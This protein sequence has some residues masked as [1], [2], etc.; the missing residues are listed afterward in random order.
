MLA[1]RQVHAYGVR[2][3]HKI[4]HLTEKYFINFRISINA[5]GNRFFSGVLAGEIASGEH[6]ESY[7]TFLGPS[8][9]R[10]KNQAISLVAAPK[11]CV[12][13][14]IASSSQAGRTTAQCT[15]Q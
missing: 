8:H 6:V 15:K 13:A 14:L 7:K 12:I 5:G 10:I 3:P 2:P 4:F 9:R 11:V 1:E